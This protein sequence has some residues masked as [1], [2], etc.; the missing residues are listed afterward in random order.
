MNCVIPAESDKPCNRQRLPQAFFLGRLLNVIQGT[1][2]QT[3]DRGRA[4]D[5]KNEVLAR[6]LVVPPKFPSVTKMFDVGLAG[7][8]GSNRRSIDSLWLKRFKFFS[9][10][11]DC[12]PCFSVFPTL[13]VALT[14][15]E[16]NIEMILRSVISA[17]Q[18]SIYGAAAD[19]CR[20]LSK[21]SR[22]S[23]KPD[24]PEFFGDDGNSY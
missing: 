17:N 15:C 23:K 2:L 3:Q 19:L 16:E 13:F 24:A 8:V 7:H 5:R 4:P 14:C 18:L 6:L 10:F 20:E 9:H 1:T 11:D 21:D 12:T 22:A